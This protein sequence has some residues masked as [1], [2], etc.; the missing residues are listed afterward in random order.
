MGCDLRR[1]H[2]V[3]ASHSGMRLLSL[4]RVPRCKLEYNYS[5]GTDNRATETN[6]I[7]APT[8]DSEIKILKQF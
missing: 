2:E 5:E 3:A 4:G 8:L 1:F 6:K 7:H